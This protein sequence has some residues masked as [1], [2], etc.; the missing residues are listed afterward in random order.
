MK[1]EI[2]N[3]IKF[4]TDLINKA[5]Y[6][7]YNLNTSEITNQQYDAS[8]QELIAL[9]KK[10]PEYRLNYS[11]TFK[12]GGVVNSKFKKIVHEVPMLSLENVFDLK[13][14][15][16]FYHRVLKK[17]SRIQFITELKIDGVA[18]N[19]KYEKGILVQATTRGNGQVGEAVIDNI[20]TIKNIPL[21]LQKDIDLEVRGEIFFKHDDFEKLNTLQ[22]KNNKPPFS[23]PRNAASGTIRLLNSD[24]VSQRILSSFIYHILKPPTFI[25]TQKE[26]LD[27]LKAMGFSVNPYHYVAD[28]F[29][30]LIPHINRYEKIKDTLPYDTDGVVIKVNQLELH[31][32]I[33]YTSKFP[34]WA[35]AYKFNSS[36][37]E[38]VVKKITFQVG[39]TGSVTP[40]AELLPVMVSG[41]VISNVSLHNYD[42]IRKK[43]IRIGDTVLIH[44]SGSIIPEIIEVIQDKRTDQTPFKMIT[45]C[46]FCQTRLDKKADEVDYFCLN[47]FCEEKQIKKIIHFVSR[48][49]MDVNVLGEKTLILFFQKGF[50]KKIS[51]LYSLKSFR[52]Q[53]EDLPGFK[54]KKV[55]NILNALET[56]KSQP[57]E[58]VL[59]ALGI[60]HIGIKV[61]KILAQKYHNIYALKEATQEDLLAIP[62]VGA[63]IVESLG[64]YFKKHQNWEEI[65]LLM[66]HN[67]QFQKDEQNKTTVQ[68]NFFKGKKIVLTGSLNHYS[69]KEA[70]LLLEEKGALIVNSVSK[71]I[72]YLICGQDSGSKLTKARALGIKIIEE[73]ELEQRLS[74]R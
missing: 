6:D 42:Y 3:K 20:K 26:V 29:E 41:S 12:I 21:K 56:S 32:F 9:E 74:E 63:K 58:R 10:Y 13:E 55:N 8:L 31:P 53:L 39:R 68:D 5:N 50:V 66:Q 40:V 51:D 1:T 34:K 70:S 64:D 65:N 57:F 14:L 54:S 69:R 7:Y 62:E 27:F 52:S 15:K 18:I 33:G 2:V 4:L 73:E 25:K 67:L 48:E 60:K 47:E 46:P 28:S 24:T 11:P 38:T 72:D 22:V 49:A 44:K 71:N 59:F 43:D 35:I 17:T 30:A 19:L 45:H 36:Q 37:G 61:A 16:D 23:N